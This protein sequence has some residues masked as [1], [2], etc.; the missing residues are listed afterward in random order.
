VREQRFREALALQA[1]GWS[2]RRIALTLHLN[3]RTV[4][5]YVQ[6]RELPKRGA[7]Y[8]QAASAITPFRAYLRARWDAG[9]HHGGQLWHELRARGYGGSL[10]SVY[11]A[12]KW[13][14]PSERRRS[15]RTAPAPG[16]RRTLSPR[17]GLWLLVRNE[18][19]LTAREQAA[20][21]ALLAAQP[22]IA[23]AAVLTTRFLALLR[24]RDSAAL[25]PWLSD[26]AA[27]E[28]VGLRRFAASLRRDRQA[29]RAALEQKWSNGQLEGQ[30][31]RVKL[32]KR[33]GYGRATFALLQRR[34]LCAA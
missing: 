2:V 13:F 19:D 6:A 7:P 27:S 22:A 15:T 32:I 11:R 21:A 34:I 31:N 3:R 18:N 20:R 10:S 9:C 29:V 1:Q 12:L 14:A 4:K 30:I 23:A 17:Q 8:L 5:R 25:D 26:A 16:S 24:E 33:V 28:L